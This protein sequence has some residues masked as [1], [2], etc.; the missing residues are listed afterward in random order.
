MQAPQP[1]G[2]K[3]FAGIPV[4]VWF[5]I[6]AVSAVAIVG[7]VVVFSG[8][9][10]DK[11]VTSAPTSVATTTDDSTTGATDPTTPDDT[12]LS[13][14]PTDD[15][16][17]LTT[18]GTDEPLEGE[19]A[20]APAGAT[21]TRDQ[22]VTAGEL[23]NIGGGW[24]LQ[25]LGITPDAT[26][27]VLAFNEFNEAPPAGSTYTTIKVA[28]G[29]F[30][31]D[32][33]ASAFMPTINAVG[34]SNIELPSECGSAPDE[35]DV[36]GG[37]FAGGVIVGNLCVVTVAGDIPVLQLAAQ[38]DFFQEDEVFLEVTTPAAATAMTALKGPQPGASSTD[39]RMAPTAIG[40]TK[41]VGDGWSV[42]VNAPARDITDAV[43]AENQF[44]DPPPAGYRYIG[45]DVTYAFNGDGSGSAFTV[46]TSAVADTNVRLSYNCG[47]IPTPLDEFSDVYTGGQ[48]TGLLCFVVPESAG[49]LTLYSQAGFDSAPVMYATA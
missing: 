33:P 42:T 25:V 3:R 49:A 27:E 5:A 18:V 19:I 7:A 39:E 48:V 28:L 8:K 13:T 40:T 16:T 47:S 38:G 41:D 12:T 4:K 30:G 36:F 11:K 37:L 21:G 20:G 26:A 29:Y 23:A 6:A 44:N 31:L 2:P 14:E 22:P 35:L 10:D 45:I 1:T 9:D 15:T 46:T 32:D 34:G 43:M 17:P 24:R